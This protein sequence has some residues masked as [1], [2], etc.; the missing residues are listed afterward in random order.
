MFFFLRFLPLFL[1]FRFVLERAT[2]I[3]HIQVCAVMKVFVYICVSVHVIICAAN[4]HFIWIRT[5]FNSTSEEDK[6]ANFNNQFEINNFNQTI[7]IHPIMCIAIVTLLLTNLREKKAKSASNNEG[8]EHARVWDREKINV[9]IN[10]CIISRSEW[11]KRGGA[12]QLL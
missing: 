6:K 8:R 1:L 2:T 5:S 11:E 10:L 9:R 7:R 3:Q 4:L 12:K